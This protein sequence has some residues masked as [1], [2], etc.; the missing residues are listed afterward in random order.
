MNNTSLTFLSYA[1]S[2]AVIIGGVWA[3]F[4]RAENTASKKGRTKLAKWLKSIDP[5]N[6]FRS[7]P[8]KFAEIF[9]LIFG[10]KHLS[11]R[12]F[13]RSIIATT[14]CVTIILLFWISFR[15]NDDPNG[16]N[17]DYDA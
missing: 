10:E 15:T 12:C 11:F 8:K 2:W 6:T 1:A 14:I 3:L 16:R 9:D 17:T 4:D 7:W 13:R 5:L